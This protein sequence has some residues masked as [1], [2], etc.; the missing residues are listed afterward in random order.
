MASGTWQFAAPLLVRFDSSAAVWDQAGG[1]VNAN[2]TVTRGFDVIEAW[3]SQGTNTAATIMASNTAAD[4]FTTAIAIGQ[5]VGGLGRSLTLNRTN[6]SFVSGNILRMT[7]GAASASPIICA[8]IVAKNTN[9]VAV[10]SA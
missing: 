3:A 8:K 10:T 5:A 1:F 2:Y 7:L 9:T 4:L 6:A